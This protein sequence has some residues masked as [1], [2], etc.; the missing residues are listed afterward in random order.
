M[1]NGALWDVRVCSIFMSN[2]CSEAKNLSY[3][4][5]VKV[6]LVVGMNKC[7]NWVRNRCVIIFFHFFL[8][9]GW[10][11]ANSKVTGSD[12]SR[13]RFMSTSESDK[14][15]K[16]IRK[17]TCCFENSFEALLE[18]NVKWSWE[19]GSQ[20][21]IMRE[22]IFL[23]AND[24]LVWQTLGVITGKQIHSFLVQVIRARC[25]FWIF[26]SRNFYGKYSLVGF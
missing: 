5:A 3:S 24:W 12:L 6:F 2:F 7:E 20:Y 26:E 18:Q 4:T 17:K 11:Y 9:S 1:G 10:T 13:P 8:G 25:L 23:W 19:T 21:L 22:V 15:G 16:I 14:V